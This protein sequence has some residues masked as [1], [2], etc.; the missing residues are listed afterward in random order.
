[1]KL[2]TFSGSY[3]FWWWRYSLD[4]EVSQHEIRGDELAKNP[5]IAP[6]LSCLT[7]GCRELGF[8]LPSDQSAGGPI[9]VADSTVIFLHGAS[10]L[11]ITA[12]NLT[13]KRDV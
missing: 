9:P 11:V 6:C 7:F 8:V 2:S 1:M 3:S 12:N 10:E 4:A 5:K 13:G